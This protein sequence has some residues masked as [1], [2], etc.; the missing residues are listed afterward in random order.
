MIEPYISQ[1]MDQLE[2]RRQARNR[3]ER[4]RRAAEEAR[5]DMYTQKLHVQAKLKPHKT[6]AEKLPEMSD[7]RTPPAYREGIS[8]E[9]DESGGPHRHRVHVHGNKHPAG[10]QP[11]Q[12]S[13][14]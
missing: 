14:K 1:D 5:A 3:V 4:R 8:L 11:S 7:L 6:R 13:G 12:T 10:A 2:G 9:A